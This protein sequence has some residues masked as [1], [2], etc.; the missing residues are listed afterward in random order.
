MKYFALSFV[1]I[2]FVACSSRGFNRGELRTQLGVEKPVVTDSQ[3]K[4]TLGRKSNL[5]KPF[6]MTIY[7]NPPSWGTSRKLRWSL[8]DKE[9]FVKALKNS[10][11]ANHIKA[12]TILPE[13]V[14]GNL[15]ELRLEAAKRGAD[16]LLT[17]SSV[18][19]VDD[20]MNKKAWF[21]WLV[22]PAFWVKGNQDDILFMSQASLWDVRN[23]FLYLDAESETQSTVAYPGLSGDSTEDRLKVAKGPAIY[24]LT[25]KL[26]LMMN[27]K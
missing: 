21:Y 10:T 16:A 5:P 7:F 14:S 11:S 8:E 17:V 27:G 3:I 26:T 20:Y 9:E 1:L 19:Q 4:E 22:I 18:A 23:E 24:E 6:S 25:Q 12:I 15:K 13:S 2:F